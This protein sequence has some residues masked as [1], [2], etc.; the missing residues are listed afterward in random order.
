MSKSVGQKQPNAW[1]LTFSKNRDRLL[2]GEIA[3]EF[4][5]AEPPGIPLM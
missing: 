5:A 2:I 1:G 4:F 3:E